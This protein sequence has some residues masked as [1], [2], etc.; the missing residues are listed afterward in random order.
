MCDFLLAG[1][2]LS[3]AATRVVEGHSLGLG[4]SFLWHEDDCM[5]CVNCMNIIA[6][7]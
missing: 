4:A 1:L 7:I 3:V 5:R 2:V 6:R